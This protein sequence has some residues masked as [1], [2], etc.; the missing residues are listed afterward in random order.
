MRPETAVAVTG[1]SYSAASTR[2]GAGS[3]EP[4]VDRS[5]GVGASAAR[6]QLRQIRIGDLPAV[7]D[8]LH[9]GFPKRNK[10]YFSA[11]LRCL[12]QYE[13]P[14]GTPKFGYLIE[15]EARIVGVLLAISS[16]T[17]DEQRRSVRC[18]VTCWYVLPEYRVY[19]PLLV[20]Q[21]GRNPAFTYINIS[22][23]AGTLQT[24][25][26]Q[27]YRR[28]SAGAFAGV[29]VLARYSGDARVA[30]F[31]ATANTTSG[32]AAHELSILKDHQQF[33][34][35][36]LVCAAA[37]GLHPFVFR[38]R[39]VSLFPL[40]SAQLIYCRDVGE[41]TRFAGPIGRFLATRGM[42]W[43]LVAASRPVDKIP[44]KYFKNRWPMYFKGPVAPSPGD[45]AYTE[46]AL[47]GF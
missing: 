7:G 16:F 17:G 9:R 36:S 24:I 1:I 42:M 34:C 39:R 45:L 44:G 46:A 11:S 28:F 6:V 18:N 2:G 43:V 29:P 40:P 38:R 33:G 41:L 4:P 23:A 5:V 22:P 30:E 47:F 14:E 35:T 32:L 8:L 10:D 13:P 15:T 31:S 27:G 20:L 37:D 25:E 21:L 19:A 12:M 3:I 26:A